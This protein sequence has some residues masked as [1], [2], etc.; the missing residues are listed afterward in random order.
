[1]SKSNEKG[2][3][4]VIGVI[5]MVALTVV[6]AAI[7]ASFTAGLGKVTRT[8]PTA[9]LVVEDG[10]ST[11]RKTGT[12]NLIQITHKGGDPIY[13]KDTEIKIA[14]K[15]APDKIETGHWNCSSVNDGIFSVG[16]ICQINVSMNNF[17]TVNTAGDVFTVM[18]VHKP[19]NQLILDADVFCE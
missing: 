1:M 2:V 17:T 19:T 14:L 11:L 18:I 16:E 10:N 4:P 9:N 8:A 3:S 5:L 15:K 12:I 6:M 13:I 7:V